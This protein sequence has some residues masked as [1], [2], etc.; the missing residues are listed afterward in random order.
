MNII[1]DKEMYL[2][3]ILDDL[4]NKKKISMINRLTDIH[5]TKIANFS[6]ELDKF[7]EKTNVP[8][9]ICPLTKKEMKKFKLTEKKELNSENNINCLKTI[10]S[11]KKV[12]ST[13]EINNSKN[14]INQRVVY[15]VS[16]FDNDYSNIKILKDTN[17]LQG[18]NKNLKSC[19]VSTMN[20]LSE[21]TENN[22]KSTLQNTS[23][24]GSI[25]DYNDNDDT[26]LRIGNPFVGFKESINRRIYSISSLRNHESNN[27]DSEYYNTISQSENNS[28]NFINTHRILKSR[29]NIKSFNE[30]KINVH[31][32]SSQTPDL[33]IKNDSKDHKQ[34]LIDEYCKINSMV[35]NKTSFK[36]QLYRKLINEYC[37][38]T[39]ETENLKVQPKSK[40]ENKVNVVDCLSYDNLKRLYSSV[41]VKQMGMQKLGKRSEIKGNFDLMKKKLSY[42]KKVI[43]SRD[44]NGR[45][46]FDN[47]SVFSL[48][49]TKTKSFI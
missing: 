28:S 47:V 15:S 20:T 26:K 10:I 21:S 48:S 45:N 25:E 41:F 12:E 29:H 4:I 31:D 39:N 36:T 8:S 14:K 7:K 30:T 16:R 6:R 18:I 5:D 11:N 2:C 40:M 32:N 19:V 43:T 38:T 27:R 22:R 46:F 17:L 35:K 13:K 34:G 33:I 44:K 23:K 24:I 37:S 42:K 3:P 49:R 9:Q 1:L